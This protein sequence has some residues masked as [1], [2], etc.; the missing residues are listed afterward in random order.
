MER[1]STKDLDALDVGIDRAQRQLNALHTLH[2]RLLARRA[3][4]SSLAAPIRRISEDLLRQIFTCAWSDTETLGRPQFTLCVASVC[5]A[6][7]EVVIDASVLW[8][9]IPLDIAHPSP[10]ALPLFIQRS[11]SRGLEID[12]HCSK[13][14]YA[15]DNSED[16][17][18]YIPSTD[19]E[20]ESD[21]ESSDVELD[22]RSDAEP[23]D[24][25]EAASDYNSDAEPD[26]NSDE[27]S[28]AAFGKDLIWR[29]RRHL[30]KILEHFVPHLHR[31]RSLSVVIPFPD[32]LEDVAA[33]LRGLA[34]VLEKLRICYLPGGKPVL[35]IPAQFQA[36]KLHTFESHHLPLPLPTSLAIPRLFPALQ[37]LRLVDARP[38]LDV[39]G[40]LRGLQPLQHLVSLSLEG[41]H[42]RNALQVDDSLRVHLAKLEV[43][44]VADQSPADISTLFSIFTAPRM[45][46]FRFKSP[47]PSHF[48]GPL[49]P[50]CPQHF[51]SLHTIEFVLE[52]RFSI[53][54]PVIS[55][56]IRDVHVQC[57][58]ITLP[59][60]TCNID[61]FLDCMA[62]RSQCFVGLSSAVI[63][64][65]W[66]SWDRPES[67]K[68]LRR[69][70]Q[71]RIQG[72]T[73]HLEGAG[74]G[75]SPVRLQEIRVHTN[76]EL[77]QDDREWFEANLDRFEW[78]QTRLTTGSSVTLSFVRAG[79]DFL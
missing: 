24:R 62:V 11:R 28:E 46:C 22:N 15:S 61:A 1:K 48:R 50:Q 78:S 6:W 69:M 33:S 10:F 51:P 54:Y 47:S 65:S 77:P 18:D 76:I 70:V 67:V 59:Y 32:D 13:H 60:C 37:S 75:K 40:L 2:D 63:D 79:C 41:G 57:V 34:D 73:P 21:V 49:I 38:L 8:S 71:N 30:T 19:S 74:I 42:I 72:G 55:E 27:E 16:D 66:D 25:S 3:L 26:Y 45:T 58:R 23:D 29:D 5:R 20:D 36:P 35:S 39:S 12:I 52:G 9:T 44:A 4:L 7:R 17:Y 64:S 43:L 56:W 68:L 53:H 14:P 31:W